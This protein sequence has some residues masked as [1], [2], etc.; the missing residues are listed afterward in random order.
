MASQLG[1]D[2]ADLLHDQCT[3]YGHLARVASARSVLRQSNGDWTVDSQASEFRVKTLSLLQSR[4]SGRLTEMEVAADR[5][6]L[7]A[8]SCLLCAD[9]Y[10][11]DF[12]AAKSHGS[13]LARLYQ[14]HAAPLDFDLLSD[15]FRHDTNL[16]VMFLTR[17]SFDL[18]SWLS[19]LYRERL[20]S[21]R[22]HLP[23]SM[24]LTT[25]ERRLDRSLSSDKLRDIFACENQASSVYLKVRHDPVFRTADDLS[26]SSADSRFLIRYLTILN[27]SRLVNHYLDAEDISSSATEPSTVSDAQVQAFTSLAAILWIRNYI[28]PNGGPKDRGATAPLPSRNAPRIKLF[29]STELLFVRLKQSLIRTKWMA[30]SR[31]PAYQKYT[32]VRLWA[33]YVGALLEQQEQQRLQCEG[34]NNASPAGNFADQ[35][36]PKSDDSTY[37]ATLESWFN[38]EFAE[39]IDLMSRPSWPLVREILR[40]F[41]YTDMMKPNGSTWFDEILDMYLRL[42]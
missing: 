6:I 16:A 24:S 28:I 29:D 9:V 5:T 12:S 10:A 2:H 18:E 34:G 7:Y 13:M 40:G 38:A 37:S 8:I 26:L 35:A 33:L 3:G 23:E 4:I 39:Q 32:R 41:L 21:I 42:K 14:D 11:R 17:S 25:M 30:Y 36:T 19:G 1:A 20:D 22:T 15:A 31:D 27:M